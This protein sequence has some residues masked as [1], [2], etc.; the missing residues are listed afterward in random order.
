MAG[1]EDD[2]V[3]CLARRR[4]DAGEG[5]SGEPRRETWHDTEW[6]AGPGESPR[7]LAAAPEYERVA[8]LEPQDALAALG[9]PDDELVDVA[10]V[11][12]GLSAAL[13]RVMERG[14]RPGK[15]QNA[16]VDER[17]MDHDLGGGERMDGHHGQEPWIA[18][19]GADEPDLARPHLREGRENVG[20]ELHALSVLWHV[21]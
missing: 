21:M 20:C 14:G 9:L 11:R 13:A 18:G 17:V 19:P 6:D 3:I 7:L 10:L 8:A 15:P 16:G 12:R 4:R 2:R 5:R 1:G